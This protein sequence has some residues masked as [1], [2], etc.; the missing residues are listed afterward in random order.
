MRAS[1]LVE[2][3]RL[4][5]SDDPA[6][7]KDALQ[8]SVAALQAVSLRIARVN[9]ITLAVSQSLSMQ[10]ILDVLW[11]QTKWVV[12]FDHLVVCRRDGGR[13]RLHLRGR[14]ADAPGP[15]PQAGQ[16]LALALRG[17]R[18]GVYHD[19]GLEGA[20]GPLGSVMVVPFLSEQEVIGALA[21]G[22]RAGSAYSADD[23]RI[24]T[25]LGLQLAAVF[26]NASR[27]TRL[28]ELA[29]DL[30]R[31]NERH[32]NALLNIMPVSVVDEL[33][34]SGS[35]EPVVHEAVTVVFVDIVGFTRSAAEMSPQAVVDSL[36]RLFGAFDLIVQRHGLEKLK[37]IGDAY[38]YAGGLPHPQPDHARRAVHAAMEIAT[39]VESLHARAD[40][41]GWRVRIGVH[42][43][44]VVAGVVGRDRLAY[45]IW[46]DTVNV[47][48]RLE[49][50]G[51]PGRINISAETRRLIAD[52]FETV[53]RG[54]MSVKG[55]GHMAMFLVEGATA[56]P[57]LIPPDSSGVP[58]LG[59][60]P[61]P[62]RSRRPTRRPRL[63]GGRASNRPLTIR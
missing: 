59:P 16:P 19:A 60:E 6:A 3:N 18:A 24:A 28:R 46:G 13:W 22:S 27:F 26:R 1:K 29:R 44:P 10:A 53:S 4:F 7:L 45:D 50:G 20:E 54:E 41:D 52:A 32:R 35:V 21:F 14:P 61:F 48:A 56:P 33:I 40:A 55:K 9:E 38:M 37:T 12:S 43:G 51:V 25:M 63:R 5:E 36:D 8:D 47:A 39:Y 23:L 62:M 58:P 49:Q 31:A 17:G 34:A 15:A 2:L 42:S 30:D 11:Q 57:R